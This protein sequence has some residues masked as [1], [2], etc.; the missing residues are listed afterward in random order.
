M[1]DLI[2]PPQNDPRSGLLHR[3]GGRS[4]QS[5]SAKNDS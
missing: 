2:S 5:A 3:S 1:S 4:F